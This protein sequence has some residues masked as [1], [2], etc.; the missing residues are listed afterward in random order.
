LTRLSFLFLDLGQSSLEAGVE[1]LAL[2][3]G[4]AQE[5]GGIAEAPTRSFQGFALSWFHRVSP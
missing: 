1:E 3:V 4:H 5:I 2:L